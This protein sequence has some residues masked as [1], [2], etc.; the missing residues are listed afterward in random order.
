M[1]IDLLL[2]GESCLLRF[3]TSV[4]CDSLKVLVFLFRRGSHSLTQLLHG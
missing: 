2:K 3:Q 4:V 1:G